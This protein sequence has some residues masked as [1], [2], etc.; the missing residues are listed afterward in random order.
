MPIYAR[1]AALCVLLC[2]A[3]SNAGGLGSRP[4]MGWSGYNYFMQNRASEG[5]SC[6][7]AAE[8]GYTEETVK[9]T[10]LAMKE[11]GL[12]ALG[13]DL[14]MLDDCWSADK[15]GADGKLVSNS[16]RWPSGMRSL[17]DYLHGLGFKWGLYVGSGALT[18]RQFP[19]SK[20]KELLDAKTLINDY[21]VDYIKLDACDENQNVTAYYPEAVAWREALTELGSDAQLYCSGPQL[22][23]EMPSSVGGF[24][25]ASTGAGT[26]TPCATNCRA[27]GYD[28][29]AKTCNSLAV[30]PH[31]VWP[32]WDS[33][34]SNANFA[35]DAGLA[36]Y[37]GP[38]HWIDSDFLLAANWEAPSSGWRAQMSVWSILAAPMIIGGDLRNISHGNNSATLELLS[39]Q[40][41]LAVHQDDLGRAGTR[42]R[43]DGAA[44]TS[45]WA[46]LLADGGR[47]VA[48]LNGNEDAPRNV[49]VSWEELWW[50]PASRCKVRDLWAKADLPGAA[51]QFCADVPPHDVRMVRLTC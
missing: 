26:F 5:K 9:A 21:A 32:M 13:Y 25:C 30:G 43:D 37:A 49:C 15:R 14:I 41:V 6:S 1:A 36:K 23:S 10:A 24:E 35:A 51:G 19:G 50:T 2:A 27:L 20:G 16:T 40:E 42:I 39:N 3:S 33:W 28:Q 31:D 38:H 18:C 46:R 34:I 8:R 29:W 22:L 45:V 11:S 48:L 17:A 4:F 7:K 47:A 12:L 44:G